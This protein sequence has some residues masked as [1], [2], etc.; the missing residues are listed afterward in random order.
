MPI[1]DFKCPD[2]GIIKNDELVK[3]PGSHVKCDQCRIK[4]KKLVPNRI[5]VDV[6]PRVGSGIGNESGV[7]LEHVSPTGQTF[8]SKKEMRKFEKETGMEL[9]YLL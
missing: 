1:F 4:M 9:G 6:F 2:C 7:Y 3:K 5:K 8:Q